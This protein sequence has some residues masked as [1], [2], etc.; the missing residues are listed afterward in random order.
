[1]IDLDK[2]MDTAAEETNK[3]LEPY[4]SHFGHRNGA[5]APKSIEELLNNERFSN[6]QA[7]L[8]AVRRG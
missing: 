1:M 5:N 6:R 8:N 4:L 7:P 2:N 3:V